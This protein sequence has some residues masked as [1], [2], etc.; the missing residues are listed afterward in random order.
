MTQETTAQ[1]SEGHITSEAL[2]E[3]EKRI[4]VKLRI[5]NIFN[6]YVSKEAVRNY[7]WGIG[8]PNP[9]WLDED[10]A[11]KT[12]YK[13][14]LPLPTGSTAFSQPGCS[15]ACLEFMPFTQGMTGLS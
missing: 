6:Q 14:L 1:I 13:K 2:E 7:A 15:R 12:R 11:K 9:L 10:Y 8:D 4:S 3:W 5:G